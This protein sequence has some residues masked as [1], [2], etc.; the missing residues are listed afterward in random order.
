MK[1]ILI[2]L[3]VILFQIKMPV[4]ANITVREL[5]DTIISPNQISK[6]IQV[7]EDTFIT[8]LFTIKVT[9]LDSFITNN[10]DPNY[11]IPV[12]K[13]Y[14]SD[15]ENEFQMQAN[16]EI[17]LLSILELQFLGYIVNYNC[18]IKDIGVLPPGTYSTR[19]QFQSQTVLFTFDTVYNLSFTIPQTQEVSSSTN[20]VNI[21]LTPDNVFETNANIL[22]D[23]TPQILIKS[24]D[25][26]ELI[27]DTTNLGNLIGKYYFQI[28]G[29]SSN[30]REYESSQIELLPNRQYVLARGEPTVTEPITGN[31]TTD[32]INIRYS[33]QNTTDRFLNEGQFNNYVNYIIQS[34]S[35]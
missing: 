7:Q 31:Y 5:G 13:L 2:L 9:A 10:S 4:F 17:T 22:N 34:R 24:N 26:W 14:L 11:K 27:L 23:T 21:T 29:V 3:L 16:T 32:Y 35:N 20:P 15:G 6:Q 1:K 12:N 19:L 25:K 33:L 18:L 30:V 28:T 8:L